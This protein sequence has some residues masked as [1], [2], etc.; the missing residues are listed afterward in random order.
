MTAHLQPGEIMLFGPPVGLWEV[1]WVKFLCPCGEGGPP[2][3]TLNTRPNQP[4]AWK[5]Q[6][7]RVSSGVDQ[8]IS[9]SPSIIFEHNEG[10]CHFSVGKD[11]LV[12][13]SKPDEKKKAGARL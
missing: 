13:H 9:L 3:I 12:W 7:A 8:P 5:F 4:P 2:V 10:K 11:G 1:W 6:T